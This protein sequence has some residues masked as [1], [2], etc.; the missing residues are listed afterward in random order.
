[1][2]ESVDDLIRKHNI[3]DSKKTDLMRVTGNILS[4]INY[5]VAFLLFLISAI[6]FSDIFME[7][8][9]ERINGAVD[10]LCTTSKGTLIQMIFLVLGYIIID[11][12]VKYEVL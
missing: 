10:G 6:I 8:V 12:V 2:S 7:N 11:L 5:K 9:L 4:N 3:N 1:M